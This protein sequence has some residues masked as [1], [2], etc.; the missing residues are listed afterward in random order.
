MAKTVS[1]FKHTH[2]YLPPS[3]DALASLPE[4]PKHLADW[5]FDGNTGLIR[6][7]VADAPN[8]ANTMELVAATGANGQLMYSCRSSSVPEEFAPHECRR[9]DKR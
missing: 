2:G 5:T 8:D 4:R 1:D 7:R 6:L 9:V 3:A